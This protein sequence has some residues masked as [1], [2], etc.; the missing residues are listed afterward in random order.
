MEPRY[1]QLAPAD[2]TN[3]ED[4]E[5]L[6]DFCCQ[7]HLLSRTLVQTHQAAALQHKH[8]NTLQR[9]GHNLF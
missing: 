5:A 2:L 9:G 6:A 7:V 4:K 3:T 8:K 1:L